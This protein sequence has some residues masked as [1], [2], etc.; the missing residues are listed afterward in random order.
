MP[1]LAQERQ[2]FRSLQVE[3]VLLMNSP[4]I[5]DVTLLDSA[6]FQVFVIDILVTFQLCVISK[7]SV[8]QLE[9]T[10]KGVG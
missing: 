6:S 8:P 9:C 4:D 10:E 5:Q 1:G 3:L 2:E 7:N